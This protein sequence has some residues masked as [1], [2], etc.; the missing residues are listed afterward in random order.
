MSTQTEF[1]PEHSHVFL[2]TAH[3]SN[4]KRTWIVVG[5]TAATM[6]VEVVAG[7]AF[8]SMALLADGFHMATHAGALAIS[9][10]AYR[11]AR[12]HANDRRFSFGTGK[13]GELAA[14][15]SALILAIIALLIGCESFLRL[16]EPIPIAFEE[17]IAVAVLGLIVNILCAWLLRGP[18]HHPLHAH[19]HTND[20]KHHG[21][22]D[23]N[24]RAAYLHVITDALT[25]VLA[26]AGLLAGRFYG[27][28]WLD[29]VMGVVGAFVIARWSWLLLKQAGSVLLDTMPDEDGGAQIRELLERGGDRV[30][31]LH[32]WRIG[33]GHVA[34]VISLRS[35]APMPPSYYKER[36]G[37]VRH[38]SHITVEVQPVGAALSAA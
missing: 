22:D 16:A 8:G 37:T 3:R 21:H 15:S 12:K 32:L 30:T 26:I 10:L 19:P 35:E 20:H 29:P 2:G 11:Y 36:I 7:L 1:Q 4:E 33:P 25:S 28:L 31:D 6:I 34:A 27:W 38:F 9:A 13:L 24:L 23:H 17:A 18:E 5:L 14:Y